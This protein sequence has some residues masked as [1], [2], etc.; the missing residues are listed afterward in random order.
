MLADY[1]KAD[2]TELRKRWTYRH[3]KA[4]KRE[5]S[6]ELD[7]LAHSLDAEELMKANRE[8][9][10]EMAISDLSKDRVSLMECSKYVIKLEELADQKIHK[11]LDD[12]CRIVHSS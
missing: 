2:R 12:H 5:P 8:V 1:H 4:Q 3:R 10:E 7:G 6:T 9:D 11:L